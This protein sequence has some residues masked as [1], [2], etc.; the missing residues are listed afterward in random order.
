MLDT[1]PAAANTGTRINKFNIWAVCLR[2]T[3]QVITV[4]LKI[5]VMKTA[6]AA[7][8]NFSLVANIYSITPFWVAVAFYFIF[9]ERITKIHL[10]GIV[11]ITIC[12]LMTG[13]S[14]AAH[15]STT[16]DSEASLHTIVPLVMAL[17]YTIAL[18]TISWTT[19]YVVKNSKMSV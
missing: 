1:S 12:I 15:H 10:L 7:H 13:L 14:S 17:I 6:A 16:T 9:K 5:L 19:R 3:V 18:T 11:L 8:I 2:T 4:V